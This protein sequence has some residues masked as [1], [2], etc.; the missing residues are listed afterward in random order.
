MK[1]KI[2]T[3]STGTQRKKAVA[4]VMLQPFF[5]DF[6]L[7]VVKNSLELPNPYSP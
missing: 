7:F 6:V 2:L 4:S 5:V 1:N 3:N